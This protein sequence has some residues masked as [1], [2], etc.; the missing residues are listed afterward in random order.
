M[1]YLSMAVYRLG[2]RPKSHPQQ[3]ASAGSLPASSTH[4][5]SSSFFSPSDSPDAWC[6]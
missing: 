1:I 3:L 4:L 5:T 6:D 2:C